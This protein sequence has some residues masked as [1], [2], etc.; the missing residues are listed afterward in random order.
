MRNQQSVS[1]D[2]IWKNFEE[3][4]IKINDF[5]FSS[6]FF[7]LSTTPKKQFYSYTI[8]QN[9][10]FTWEVTF[11]PVVHESPCTLLIEYVCVY[12]CL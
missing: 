11:F 4:H 10:I 9:L 7:N 1:L 3:I 6:S 5:N 8:L 2:P 12:V